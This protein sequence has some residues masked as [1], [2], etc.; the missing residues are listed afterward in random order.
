[1]TD[2]RVAETG[3]GVMAG[4]AGPG[5]LKGLRVVEVAE[6]K[7]HPK[8]ELVSLVDAPSFDLGVIHYAS[9]TPYTQ[10]RTLGARGLSYFGLDSTYA[11]SLAIVRRIMTLEG[12]LAKVPQPLS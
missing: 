10:A 1:M 8:D 12:V 7:R 2:A 9:D 5:M 6:P 4:S 11:S 3:P